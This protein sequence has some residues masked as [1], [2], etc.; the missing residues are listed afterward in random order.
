M[1]N[2]KLSCLSSIA[3]EK[4]ARRRL[5]IMLKLLTA[6]RRL[7]PPSEILDGYENPE[8]VDVI[9]QKTKAYRP[10][11][12]YSEISSAASVLDFGGGCGIH[13]KQANSPHARWTIV[14]TPAMV[15]RAKELATDRLQFFTSISD[16]A[17]WLG[18]ID[19]MHSNGALQYT[20]KPMA[21]LEQLCSLRAPVMLWKPVLL[22][23]RVRTETQ[24]SRLND[25][26]PAK[27]E[28]LKDKL[29]RIELTRIPVAE[30]IAAHRNYTLADR[31][32]D[33]FR[34]VLR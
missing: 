18:S 8:L 15:E 29:V 26:G 11:E 16:A 28:R 12:T 32:A 27:L 14:E 22:S 2:P 30:F 7:V 20:L 33:W 34:F 25:N 13:Y 5:R 17:R 3:H 31:G 6:L 10:N 24:T 21:T 4:T 19:V 9:F 23:D 1:L